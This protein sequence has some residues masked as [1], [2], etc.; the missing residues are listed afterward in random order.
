VDK[1]AIFENMVYKKLSARYRDG[2]LYF[3]RTTDKKE[4]DFIIDSEQKMAIESKYAYNGKGIP[5]LDY[6]VSENP[7]FEKSIISLSGEK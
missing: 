2:G 7:S 6:F 3:W 4:I 5:H 1:G